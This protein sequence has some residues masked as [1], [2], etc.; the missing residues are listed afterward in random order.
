MATVDA[1]SGDGSFRGE[2]Y[3]KVWQWDKKSAFWILNTR[4]EKPHGL[5]IVTDLSF[6]PNS[7][8]LV[9]IGLDSTVKYWK[10]RHTEGPQ[11]GML[12]FIAAVLLK[13]NTLFQDSGFFDRQS[14]YPLNSPSPL[15][16][17]AMPHCLS[18]QRAKECPCTIQSLIHTFDL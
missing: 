10:L 18:C 12:L 17:Q 11:D 6:S 13:L 9:S 5:Q 8:S 1:R 4:V 14:P 15:V 3:L 7:D 16:G 2:V